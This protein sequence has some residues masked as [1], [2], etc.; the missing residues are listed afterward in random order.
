MGFAVESR[1][2]WVEHRHGWSG[3]NLEKYLD[4]SQLHTLQNGNF[5]RFNPYLLKVTKNDYNNRI[6]NISNINWTD[7]SIPVRLLQTRF[8][9]WRFSIQ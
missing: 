9:N 5:L 3:E 7:Y 2:I 8:H 6:R 4:K 1:S